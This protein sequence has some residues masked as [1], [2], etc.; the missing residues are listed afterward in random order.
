ME[1]R[2]TLV[3]Y[4]SRRAREYDRIYEKPERQEALAELRTL[5]EGWTDGESV[6]ELACGTGYWTEV[7]ARR[8]ASVL[9]TDTNATVLQL[10]RERS[11]RE[12]CVEVRPADAFAPESI[13]GAFTCAFA[14]FWVSHLRRDGTGK[15]LNRLHRRLGPGATVVLLDNRFVEGSNT[16][17]SRTDEYGNTMQ[18]RTLATGDEFEIVK[19]FLEEDDVRIAAGADA[20]DLEFHDLRYFW[21]VRYRLRA[22]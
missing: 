19:N 8:A 13:P 21:A 17:I 3:D 22:T 4:Y 14:G 15:F 9:A 18:M 7:M 5:V 20:T 1:S 2:D 16:P 10:A 11:D 12:G 6:L